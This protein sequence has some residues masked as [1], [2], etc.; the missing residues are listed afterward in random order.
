M[1]AGIIHTPNTIH[2]GLIRQSVF[3]SLIPRSLLQDMAEDFRLEEWEEGGSIDAKV[4]SERF[5][6][7][8]DGELA[9]KR[10]NPDSGQETLIKTLHAGDSFDVIPLLDQQP[11][12]FVIEVLSALKLITVP[13]ET[14]RHW[15]WTHPELNQQFLPYLAGR[16]REQEVLAVEMTGYDTATR[17]SRILLNYID[18]ISAYNGT[19]EDSHKTVLIHGLSDETLDHMVASVEQ[20]INKHL[21]HWQAQEASDP[22]R[23]EPM[24]KEL[25]ALKKQA[26]SVLGNLPR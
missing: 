18:K 5:F 17:L 23:H 6:I 21:Q 1:P 8:L 3:F 2:P 22:S 19:F 24:I 10:V 11:H 7:L 26:A 15:L 13:M 9:L 14:M 4:L 20:L 25:E 12:A 16:V